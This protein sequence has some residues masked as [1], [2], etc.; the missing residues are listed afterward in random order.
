[1]PH[2]SIAR[3][4]LAQRDS[5]CFWN[6]VA[7]SFIRYCRYYALSDTERMRTLLHTLKC[8]AAWDTDLSNRLDYMRQV[9]VVFSHS[10]EEREQCLTR[11][12]LTKQT[13][14]ATLHLAKD[15]VGVKYPP[16]TNR[17]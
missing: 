2:R 13:E 15:G 4:I 12:D 8:R 3:S 7:R 9:A 14:R 10:V 16:M 17:A 6:L 1:M 11:R 5:S